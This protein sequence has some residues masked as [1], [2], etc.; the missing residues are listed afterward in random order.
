MNKDLIQLK[1]KFAEWLSET[2]GK[3]QNLSNA[4]ANEATYQAFHYHSEKVGYS[5]I[6]VLV[7]LGAISSEYFLFEYDGEELKFIDQKI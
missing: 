6:L 4:V 1:T 5:G 3:D 7:V 2:Y